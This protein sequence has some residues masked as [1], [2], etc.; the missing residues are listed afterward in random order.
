M[1]P[2]INRANSSKFE[3]GTIE[4]ILQRRD[5]GVSVFDAVVRPPS[6]SLS[7]PGHQLVCSIDN[8]IQLKGVF[9]N[10]NTQQQCVKMNAFY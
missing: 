6:N 5:T 2:L 7:I 8:L 4:S 10:K 9:K 1:I 3:A